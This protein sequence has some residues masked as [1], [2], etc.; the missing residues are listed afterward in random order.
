M[1]TD[2]YSA[3]A[4]RAVQQYSD[5]YK[6]AYDEIWTLAYYSACSNDALQGMDVINHA[7]S[8]AHVMASSAADLSHM[9]RR[10]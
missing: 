8:S 1:G 4:S 9:L 5:D 7:R 3:N 6:R 10:N 2:L